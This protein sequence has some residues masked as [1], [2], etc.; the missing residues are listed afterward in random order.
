[1]FDIGERVMRSTPTPEHESVVLFARVSDIAADDKTVGGLTVV[2]D[3]VKHRRFAGRHAK[4]VVDAQR[5]KNTLY[6]FVVD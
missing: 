1:M 4:K 5:E 3:G 6:L 2:S